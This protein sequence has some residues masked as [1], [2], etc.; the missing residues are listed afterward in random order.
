MS[1][2]A[3]A[4]W[5]ESGGQFVLLKKTVL[6]IILRAIPNRLWGKKLENTKFREG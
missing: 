5:L 3:K 1:E 2:P 4:R 6:T